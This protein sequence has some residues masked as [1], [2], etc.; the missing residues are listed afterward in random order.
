LT[1]STR[2]CLLLPLLAALIA[3]LPATALADNEHGN[4][5]RFGPFKGASGDSGTCGPDW[6][7]DTYQREFAVKEA[8]AG[9]WTV[10]ESFLDGEFVTTGPASPGACE[11]TQP[12]GLLVAAGIEGE[13]GGFLSG[14]VSGGTFNPEGCDTT[15]TSCNT[16]AGFIA[17]VF[18]PT[19]VYNISSFSFHYTA[20]GEDLAFRHWVNA[21]ADLGGNRGDIAT[22]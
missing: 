17:A 9:T 6:A 5:N 12:H 10:K 16:T 1:S 11:G 18:G 14:T 19:A 8:T 13:F 3:L 4:S 22:S 20:H 2:R 21:S 7:N 15:P